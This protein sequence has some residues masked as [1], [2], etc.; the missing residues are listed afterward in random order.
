MTDL[1]IVVNFSSKVFSDSQKLLKES[2]P[3]FLSSVV[4]ILYLKIDVIFLR[5][6]TELGE[7]G[8]YAA[9]AR[10]SE[11]LYAAPVAIS[12]V[13]FPIIMREI[14]YNTK[15]EKNRNQ[16]GKS[17]ERISASGSTTR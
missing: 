2:F 4:V 5:H 9:A 15:T 13:F 7:V 11:M 16:D 17:T 6:F 3:L 14:N 8:Y 1:Q 10:I 12:T